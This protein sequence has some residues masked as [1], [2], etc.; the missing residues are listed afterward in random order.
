[1]PGDWCICFFHVGLS[2]AGGQG[3]ASPG[4]GH[5]GRNECGFK[6]LP[7]LAAQKH[8]LGADFRWFHGEVLRE[9][10]C[11]GCVRACMCACVGGTDA[12]VSVGLSLSLCLPLSHS[13]ALSTGLEVQRN[14]LMD[15]CKRNTRNPASGHHREASD[16]RWKANRVK[17]IF[18]QH[19]LQ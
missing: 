9:A 8:P 12:A 5:P 2:V 15:T 13:L 1:M 10:H 11:R 6:R 16:G 3:R 18:F 17:N 4:S 7:F 19:I 14:V